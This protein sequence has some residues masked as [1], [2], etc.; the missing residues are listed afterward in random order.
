MPIVHEHCRR[1]DVRPALQATPLALVVGGSLQDAAE[2]LLD[3]RA[4]SDAERGVSEA[5]KLACAKDA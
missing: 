2:T 4:V 1:A 3:D 5:I